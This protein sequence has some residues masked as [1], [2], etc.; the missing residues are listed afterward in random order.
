MH[1][2]RWT[3]GK[4]FRKT[5]DAHPDWAW[6]QQRARCEEGNSKLNGRTVVK[7]QELFRVSDGMQNVHEVA[8]VRLLRVKGSQRPHSEEEMIWMEWIDGKRGVHF[9]RI[10][11]MEGMAHLIPFEKDKVWLV[12]NRIDFNIWNELYE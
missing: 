6:V 8:F 9:I 3:G 1:H 10:S 12:N 2:L 4:E 7:L 5:G 11:D